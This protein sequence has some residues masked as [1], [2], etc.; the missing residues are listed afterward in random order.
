MQATSAAVNSL[1]VAVPRV[2]GFLAVL[3]VGWILSSLVAR[4]IVAL[5]HALRFNELARR[6]GIAELVAKWLI[7]FVVLVVAFDLLGL[8]AILANALLYG[9]IG[10]L[11]LAAGLAFGLAGR[12]RAA[13]LLDDWSRQTEPLGP[14]LEQSDPGPQVEARTGHDRVEVHAEQEEVLEHRSGFDRRRM[15]RPGSDRRHERNGTTG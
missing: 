12:D 13:K 2:L 3:L 8:T 4:G 5:L 14:R 11:A 10:G 15:S 1:T 9:V 7:R 6:S